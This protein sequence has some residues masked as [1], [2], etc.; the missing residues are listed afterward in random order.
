MGDT[1]RWLLAALPLLWALAAIGW[2]KM[3]AMKAALGCYALAAGLALFPFHASAGEVMHFTVHGV[4]LA[5]IVVY[6]L[7][8]GL[9]LHHVLEAGGA[10]DA[11]SVW[12]SRVGRTP[13]EQALL[14]SAALGPFFEAVS[15][16]GLAVVIVAP[17]Y[18]AL[19]FPA[20]KAMTLALLTQSAVPWGALA[21]GTVINAE[22]SGVPLREL[23]EYSAWLH[24]PLYLL[25][26]CAVVVI[27]EGWRAVRL[28]LDGILIVF[29]SL[30]SVT[31][32]VSVYVSVE[33]AGAAAGAMAALALVGYWQ[34]QELLGKREP[35]EKGGRP[36]LGKALWPYAVLV[37]YIFATHFFP[38]I[39]H[40]A[41]TAGVWHWPAYGFRLELLY[42]PGFALCLAAVAAFGW[43]R[44]RLAE[45]VAC[46]QKTLNRV[47]P[48]A[49]ATM[50]FIAMSSV[51]DGAGM[52]GVLASQAAAWTGSAFLAVSPLVGALAGWMSG[53]NSAA[54]AM[55]SPFQRAMADQLHEPAIW[56]AAA[57]N[58][59]A[60]NMTMASPA[61]LALVAATIGRPGEEGEAMRL[62]GPIV[63]AALVIVVFGV[64][65]GRAAVS[66]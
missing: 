48:A 13:S 57:Q 21:I 43:H 25:Y 1:I 7:V 31:W 65:V 41:T 44:L 24:V 10:I 19:G 2:R 45:G 46:L 38:A 49:V 39:R 53:S 42:S 37:G 62:V 6:V 47:F 40:I 5:L 56:Y 51:M 36:P 66:I 12:I 35:I 30:A 28:H 22:L 55:F 63:G 8:F 33:L 59:A 34:C 27:S 61:R 3:P 26:V 64:L 52:T 16:F 14:L 23:G 54:N 60:S 32:A 4:L 50:G 29:V 15:G 9:L 18:A 20:R 58:V 11:L 17:L